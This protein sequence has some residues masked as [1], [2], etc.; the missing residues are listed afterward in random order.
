MTL[1]AKWVP[2]GEAGGP[3]PERAY[4]VSFD[5]QGGSRVPSVAG[6]A[7]GSR[8][9]APEPPS[10]MG[11]RFDGW[12]RD[13]D[14]ADRWD[15]YADAVLGDTVLYAKWAPSCEISSERRGGKHIL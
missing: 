6:V 15:F 7:R 5:S 12:F 11:F 2:D 13:P 14:C 10:R 3:L 9:S 1:Y 4:K 8:I